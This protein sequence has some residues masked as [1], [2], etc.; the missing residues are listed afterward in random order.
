MTNPA[1]ASDV[2]RWTQSCP[3]TA[4]ALRA[5]NRIDALAASVRL[6]V[7]DHP[8]GRQRLASADGL[9]RGFSR[10]VQALLRQRHANGRGR[11]R[12]DGAIVFSIFSPLQISVESAPVHRY[13]HLE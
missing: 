6:D 3:R 1:A 11:E 2:T 10:T 7:V 9:V 8:S 12:N 13:Q 4:G 5:R